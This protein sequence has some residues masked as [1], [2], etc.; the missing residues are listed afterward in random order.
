MP[1]ASE[2]PIDAAMVMLLQN[3]L[4][5]DYQALHGACVEP[6][7]HDLT[8]AAFTDLSAVVNWLGN[9]QKY[10][11]MT[12]DMSHGG[13]ERWYELEFEKGGRV[14]LLVSIDQAGKL[15]G[16]EFQGPGYK[17]AEQGAIAEQWREFKVYDFTYL[18][19]D[20]NPLPEGAP[21]PGNRV[22]YEIIVGG[23]EALIGGHHLT[24][25]KIVY[26]AEGKEVFHEPIEYDAKF[27]AN[28]EGIPR[29]VVRGHLEVPGAGKWEMDLKITDRNAHRD[30]DY[31]HA[32]ETVPAEEPVEEPASDGDGATE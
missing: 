26:D 28:A 8:E 23:I 22:E 30:I 5:G 18:D 15:I 20:G 17:E 3:L 21:I 1:K 25:E 4:D 16:F 10:E 6:L 32:F 31:R 9:V 24:I 14:E 13:G 29:G 27:A 2:D 12:T 7:T 11:V 19:A